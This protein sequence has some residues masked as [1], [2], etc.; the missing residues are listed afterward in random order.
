MADAG[1]GHHAAFRAGPTERGSPDVR[2]VEVI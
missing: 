1:Y 2:Q